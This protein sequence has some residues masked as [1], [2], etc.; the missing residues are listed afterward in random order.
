MIVLADDAG[1]TPQEWFAS[2]PELDERMA[3]SRRVDEPSDRTAA[4]FGRARDVQGRRTSLERH[5]DAHLAY[6]VLFE[7]HGCREMA[8]FPYLLVQSGYQLL[9]FGRHCSRHSAVELRQ[10]EL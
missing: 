8:P 3:G 9:D 10:D 2:G 1:R 4:Q 5:L 6:Q 7:A